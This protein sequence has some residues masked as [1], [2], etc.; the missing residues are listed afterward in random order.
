MDPST[1]TLLERAENLLETSVY[2]LDWALNREVRG[3]DPEE[4]EESDGRP[5]SEELWDNTA[6]LTTALADQLDKLQALL[7][8]MKGNKG[9]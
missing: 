8:L 1:R 5:T 7:A 4:G 3:F 2:H 6:D 9:G